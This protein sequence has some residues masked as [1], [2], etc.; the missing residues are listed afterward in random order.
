MSSSVVSVSVV[1]VVVV[2]VVVESFISPRGAGG[3]LALALS[4]HFRHDA[5]S[6]M[7]AISVIIHMITLVASLKTSRVGALGRF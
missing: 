3:P 6:V 2:V 5:T 1:V 7:R 4:F